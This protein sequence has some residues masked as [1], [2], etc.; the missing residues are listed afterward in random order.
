LVVDYKE[1]E[2]HVFIFAYLSG[3]FNRRLAL[4]RFNRISLK[5]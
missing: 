2:L 3:E 1:D 5:N 4:E